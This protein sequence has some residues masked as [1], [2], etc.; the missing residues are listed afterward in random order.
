MISM[1]H[2]RSDDAEQARAPG[3]RDCT[4]GSGPAAV[5]QAQDYP[6]RTVRIIVPY[7]A[8][9]ATDIVARVM[10]EWLT[11]KW[12]QPVVIDNRSGAAGNIGTETAFKS[13]PD[14]YTILVNAPSPM[15][16]N[17]SLYA[18]LN[19]EPSEFVPV[20]I[21]TVIPIGL[22]VNPKKIPA[23]TVAEFIAYAKAN[24]GKINAATQ[25]TGTT[26]HLTTEW[27]QMLTGT[28]FLNVPFRGSALALP[29][30]IA[31]DC[32]F[33][34]DNLT[35]SMQHV[36]DGRLKMLAV[37]TQK[38][39]PELPDTPTI[40]ETLPN[41]VSIDLGRGV[42]AAQDAAAHRRP[43][44][45]RLQRRA[46]AARR[47]QAVPRQRQRTVRHHA[48][49]GGRFRAWRGRAL[50]DRHQGGRHQVRSDASASRNPHRDNP[51]KRSTDRILT[52]HVGSL[53]RPADLLDM[54]QAKEQGQ[55]VDEEA[56]AARL[57]ERGRRDRAQAGRA[58]H[59]RRR[60]RRIRQA[61]LR[62]LRQRAARRLRG[63]QGRAAAK[64]VG[65]LARGAVVPG[66][67]RARP[68]R[69]RASGRM[70]CTGPIT[71]KGQA[72]LQRD[73]D[74]LKAARRGAK[75]GEAFMPAIS[76]SN[77][78]DWQRN[79]YYKT[80]EE[81]LFAIAEAMR[82]EYKAIVDA[83]FLL[84]IDDPRL[85]TY[86]I[87]KPDLTMAQNAANGRRG[88]SRRSTTRCATSRRRRSATTPATAS[89]WGRASTTCEL[90]D[91]IDIILKINAGAYSFEAANPRHEHEWKLWES[92][93][94]PEDKSLIPG[95]ITHSTVLVE[96]P[97]LVA[98]R[99]E[100]FASV[101][102]REN[103][104]AGADCGFATFAGSKE[105]HP[106]I[107]WAKFQ[108]LVEGARIASKQLWG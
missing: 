10:Q 9:G 21:L 1:T 4:R 61:E 91:I 24:P 86:W 49:G 107:V 105:V 87:K 57:R 66:V 85:V 12:S 38:R 14:G 80:D 71:Y 93:K 99:I 60:R 90:K 48:A 103:V 34:F 89:T 31:G 104:I 39:L 67:L 82:E 98:E 36:R 6:T 3:R 2:R 74:N 32:D 97:E 63:R 22:I 78:E 79:A 53:P 37:T 102:G 73:I 76:P 72:Q 17:Q 77:V 62:H 19:F 8:G 81:Y 88:A 15:T 65:R 42:P 29:A 26:S 40:A 58:R 59:R 50:E 54:M 95:V 30:L 44:E 75:P 16:V 28:K 64:P 94:L 96:H 35:S 27:L 23:N 100:R 33:M 52:T 13:D 69:P 106:S 45:R 56:Y 20:T 92:V 83:G 55:Q 41:F 47:D 11:R 43:A 5:G 18:K 25:G 84:Q 70:V 108:A 51:M 101:V 7:P 68:R 46:Q